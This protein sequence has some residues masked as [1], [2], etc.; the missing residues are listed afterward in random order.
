[1]HLSITQMHSLS[2]IQSG[3]KARS[4]LQEPEPNELG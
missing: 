1:M 3:A 2:P 4:I